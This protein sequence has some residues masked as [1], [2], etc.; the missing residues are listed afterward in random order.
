MS[1]RKSILFFSYSLET[2]F[3]ICKSYESG[4]T[5]FMAPLLQMVK[6]RRE[7]MSLAFF[8]SCFHSLMNSLRMFRL[9][10]LWH[11][12]F[13]YFIVD[14]EM[15]LIH[16]DSLVRLNAYSF[17]IGFEIHSFFSAGQYNVWYSIHLTYAA[18]LAL[19]SFNSFA[20]KWVIGIE[21]IFVHS[22]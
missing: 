16:V 13:F 18:L 6:D 19:V 20:L 15:C 2:I 22:I 1:D 11:F 7:K 4:I 10:F 21:F 17:L 14:L 8:S 9:N 12:H 3:F 5:C